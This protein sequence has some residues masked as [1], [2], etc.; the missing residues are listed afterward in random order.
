MR[1]GPKSLLTA[2]AALDVISAALRAARAADPDVIGP[3][4]GEGELV[5][6]G[7][8]EDGP[9]RALASLLMLRRGTA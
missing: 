4:R 8:V 5:E 3:A 1:S 9:E 2:T 6:D 7:I